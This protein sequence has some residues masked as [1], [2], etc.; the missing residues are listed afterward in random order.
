MHMVSTHI[1]LLTKVGR[2]NTDGYKYTAAA[3]ITSVANHNITFSQN[4]QFYS[5][6][7]MRQFNT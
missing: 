7:R 6:Q 2:F 3:T 5:G 1:Q 4:C